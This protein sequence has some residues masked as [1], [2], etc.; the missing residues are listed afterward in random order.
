[1]DQDHSKKRLA[2]STNLHTLGTQSRTTT[3]EA[4]MLRQQQRGS[5]DGSV[6]KKA[7]PSKMIGPRRAA[8]NSALLGKFPREI[9]GRVTN[10]QT[11][12][13]QEHT[14]STNTVQLCSCGWFTE[15]LD[16]RC[17]DQGPHLGPA[18]TPRSLLLG[19]RRKS[20]P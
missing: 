5:R 2:Q 6:Y 20:A 10:I 11:T 9:R 18:A 14:G 15:P 7:P 8:N 19:N 12:A 16:T 13:R 3:A 4:K 17:R 1:M